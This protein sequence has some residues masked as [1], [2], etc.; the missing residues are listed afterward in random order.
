MLESSEV[1]GGGSTAAVGST[2]AFE[3][4]SLE[5]GGGAL[6]EDSALGRWRLAL[7]WAAFCRRKVALMGAMMC[8]RLDAGNSSKPRCNKIRWIKRGKN[9][10]WAVELIL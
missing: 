7:I 4:G 6:E 8:T 1:E 9:R 5:E 3:V 2:N 10:P